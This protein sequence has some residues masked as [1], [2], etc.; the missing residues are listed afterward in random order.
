MNLQEATL[1]QEDRAMPRII[2]KLVLSLYHVR[3]RV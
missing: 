3:Y 2:L 1:S